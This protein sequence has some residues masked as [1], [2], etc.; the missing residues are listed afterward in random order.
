LLVDWIDTDIAPQR[1]RVAKTLYLTERRLIARPTFI[2]IV[3][4]CVAG[5]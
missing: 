4:P 2:F 1:R 5:V 3:D